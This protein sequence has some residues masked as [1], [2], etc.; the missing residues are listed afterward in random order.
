VLLGAGTGSIALGAIGAAIVVATAVDVFLTI[1]N[2]DGFDFL[3]TRFHH[4]YWKVLRTVDRPLPARL[5]HAALSI[6]SASMLPATVALW[7]GLEIT[8]FALVYLPG[9]GDGSFKLNGADSSLGTAYYFSGGAISSLTFGD[10]LARSGLDRAVVDLETIVGLATFTLALGYVVTTF[11]V[12]GKLENLH[13]RVERHAERPGRPSSILRRHFRGGEPSDL[14]SYLQL[15]ADDLEDY[16]QGLR[17]YPVVYYFHTRR[18]DRSIPHVFDALG[19]LIALLHWGLPSDEPM[20]Q[21]PFLAALLDGYVATVTRLQRTFVGPVPLRLPEP[22]GREQFAA[23]YAGREEDRGV[24]DFR[25]LERRARDAAGRD[26]DATGDV[27]EAYER[28]REWLPFA[29][30]QR[31]V[32]DR[33]ADALGYD[34]PRVAA[35]S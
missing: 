9:L 6:G 32:L 16:D 3:A 27:D 26:T 11:N 25:D 35:E 2:Y 4:L 22:I 8:G 23:A 21:D 33:V 24:R 5:R 10:V 30:R 29:Y 17:R 34:P 19:N 13:G 12:L 7:L 18:A 15:L 31:V 1:F 14:P 28:Y 20:S